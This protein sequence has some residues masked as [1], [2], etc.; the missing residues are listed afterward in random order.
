M[1][2]FDRKKIAAALAFAALFCNKTSAMNTNKNGVKN[3]QTLGA[4]GG[5]FL[6]LIQK[7]LQDLKV[8]LI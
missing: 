2:K 6:V 8:C 5:R 3:S 4:V 7:R 1:A